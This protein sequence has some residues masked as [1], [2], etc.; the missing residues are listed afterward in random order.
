MS[1][2]NRPVPQEYMTVTLIQY[3]QI[4]GHATGFFYGNDPENQFLVTNKHVV[5]PEDTDPNEIRILLRGLQN[6]ANLD[7][8]DISLYDGSG[9]ATWLTH[10]TDPDVDIAMIPLE[11]DLRQYGNMAISNDMFLSDDV[12]LKAG[13]QAMIIGHPIKGSR[14]YIPVARSALISSPYGVPF[15]GMRCFATD[16]NMHSG[17]SGSPVFTIPSAIQEQGDSIAFFAGKQIYFLGVHSATLH[18]DHDDAEGP[19]NLNL[20]WYAELIEDILRAN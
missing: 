13:E 6:A 15:Q 11:I 2:P 9:N 4:Q 1:M 16:A 17:T 18:S 19:L 14:P 7:Y 20:T 3:P 8:L 5:D 10:P 12:E